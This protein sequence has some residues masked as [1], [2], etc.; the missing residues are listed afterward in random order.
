MS[1]LWLTDW[2]R[3]VEQ[4]SVWAESAI[5]FAIVWVLSP[6]R[7]YQVLWWLKLVTHHPTI[8]EIALFQPT[9]QKNLQMYIKQVMRDE[10]LIQFCLFVPSIKSRLSREV[11]KV[12]RAWRW[13]TPSF[14]PAIS[15]KPVQCKVISA[16]WTVN[17]AQSAQ[18][19][20]RGAQWTVRSAQWTVQLNTENTE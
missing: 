15:S 11:R 13:L 7:P 16:Q 9:E 12:L 19:T 4:Y 2:L 20:V 17:I 1:Q 8:Q 10:H 5:Y 14:L 18:R 3:E 6:S